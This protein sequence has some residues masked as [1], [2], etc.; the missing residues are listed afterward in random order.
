MQQPAKTSHRKPWILL[1]LVTLAWAGW[2][3][4][5]S[6]R[7]QWRRIAFLIDEELQSRYR[8][9]TDPELGTGLFI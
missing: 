4:S 5:V 8:E 7:R 6:R 3:Y 9:R 1:G 2:S